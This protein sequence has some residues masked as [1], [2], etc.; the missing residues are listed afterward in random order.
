MAYMTGGENDDL[1]IIQYLPMY[2]AD[3]ARAWSDLRHV[4]IS[5]FQGTYV[6]LG[7][8]WDLRNCRQK[9]GETLRE[10]IHCFSKQ[11]DD[12]PDV[13]DADVIGYFIAGMTNESLV[14]ELGCNQPCSTWKL[15]DIARAP[16]GR[17]GEPNQG[18][19][20]KD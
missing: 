3:S 15:F 1:F 11:S 20:E 19:K 2:L 7:N 12:L 10:Y 16:K 13:E 4:F 9:P 17:Q 5:N 6:R 8:S 14:H 18:D